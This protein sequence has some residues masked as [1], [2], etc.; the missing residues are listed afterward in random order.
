MQ[1]PGQQPVRMGGDGAVLVHLPDSLVV[2]VLVPE[3]QLLLG[4][5]ATTDR[6]NDPADDEACIG[7]ARHTSPTDFRSGNPAIVTG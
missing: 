6:G 7:L 2:R 3:A 5:G 1:L 4:Q